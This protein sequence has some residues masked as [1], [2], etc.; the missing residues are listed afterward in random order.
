MAEKRELEEWA[1]AAWSA[2]ASYAAEESNPYVSLRLEQFLDEAPGDV[3]AA[4]TF[5]ILAAAAHIASLGGE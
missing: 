1:V 2:L 4:G 3:A 5:K